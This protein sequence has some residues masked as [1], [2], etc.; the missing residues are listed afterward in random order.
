MLIPTL[1]LLLTP[2]FLFNSVNGWLAMT[3]II[4]C[5]RPLSLFRNLE[6]SAQAKACVGHW[7]CN[8]A[9]AWVPT[10]DD[11]VALGCK[12]IVSVFVEANSF[13]FLLVP[14]VICG[15]CFVGG[16]NVLF[17]LLGEYQQFAVCGGIA[18][19]HMPLFLNHWTCI[20]YRPSVKLKLS[21]DEE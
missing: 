20:C 2:C 5:R 17:E 16:E 19:F 8:H 10:Q 18:S 3:F 9:C 6:A 1:E 7:E 21:N 14:K 13:L 11:H 12:L 15:I 4:T